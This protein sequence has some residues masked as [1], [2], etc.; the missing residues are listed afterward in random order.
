M[1][2]S[3]DSCGTAL[4]AGSSTCRACG[5]PASTLLAL[6]RDVVGRDA[7]RRKGRR[8]L[9]VAASAVLVAGAGAGAVYAGT[10]LG[11]GGTQPQDVLPHDA[12]GFLSLDL[13]PA[14]GQKIAAY[15][16][17]QKFPD[18]GVSGQDSLKDDLLRTL[19]ADEEDVDY[20]RDLEP[21]LGERAGLAVLAPDPETPS[22]PGVMAAVQVTDRAE[23][24]RGLAALAAQG[25]AD[26]PL[27]WAFTP[28]D[29]YVLLSDDQ[30][31]V[32]RAAGSQEHLADNPRFVEGVDALDGDHIAF[33]WMDVGAAYASVP[34]E[35]R[36][37]VLASQPGFDP[38]GLVVVGARVEDDGV[39][40]VGRSIG[41]SLGDSPELQAL[42][43]GEWTKTPPVGLVEDLPAD[44]LGAFS[45]TGLGDG[46]A[47]L[48]ASLDQQARADLDELQPMLDEYG[49][50]LPDDLPVLL[51]GEL[52]V[53][54]GGDFSADGGR[55][56]AHVESPDGARA[57]ELVQ[58]ALDSAPEM[59]PGLDVRTVDGG[60]TVTYDPSGAGAST[61]RLG[62]H[63][64]FQR[65]VPDAA[66][67]RLTYYVDLTRLMAQSG[68]Q[69][70]M[71]ET[72]RRNLEP[73]RAAGYSA[74]LDGGGDATFRFR[75]TVE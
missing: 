45:V 72:E 27:H 18:S 37:D 65:T 15:R 34:P 52:A 71:T 40:V 56:L 29:D 23:A 53:A 58:R 49:L 59:S 39:Q 28:D 61:E 24:E 19:L 51:G 50:R 33:G 2:R 42:V 9:L 7:E 36:E 26:E 35:S 74:T 32:D 60:Y 12:I 62:D 4:E 64:L 10:A 5:G 20:D 16:L 11:G 73:L 13:D 17:S 57:V 41:V 55:V 47:Q 25:S 1:T 21:W 68:A 6:Q 46:L 54:V 48:Y 38:E 70:G 66:D 67:S 44:S 63:E 69:E 22:E 31:A 30:A 8:G 3:C 14:A 75:L 43:D